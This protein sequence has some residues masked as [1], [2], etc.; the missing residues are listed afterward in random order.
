MSF[1]SEVLADNPTVFYKMNEP[2]GTVALDSSGNGFYGNYNALGV[3]YGQPSVVRGLV[4][5]S[6]I[7]DG[8]NG[9]LYCPSGVVASLFSGGLTVEAWVNPS[10]LPNNPNSNRIASS[11]N[12]SLDN[13]GFDFRADN[14]KLYVNFGNGSS[15]IMASATFPMMLNMWYHTVCTWDGTNAL[16]YV[17]GVLA[18]SA[19]STLGAITSDAVAF[20]FGYDFAIPGGQWVGSMTDAVL[21]NYALPASR[22]FAHYMAGV[23]PP[24]VDPFFYG[25]QI[26]HDGWNYHMIEKSTP[27]AAYQQS[28][29]PIARG[30]G[31]K[32]TG[33]R[34]NE[35]TINARIQV[36][37]QI[38][39]RVDLEHL[40]DNLYQGLS[41]RQ[42]P[43]NIHTTDE[44]FWIADATAAAAQLGPGNVVSAEVPVTFVS[45]QPY[46]YAP[47]TQLYQMPSAAMSFVSGTYLWITAVQAISVSGNAPSCP[48]ITITNTGAVTITAIGVYNITD[49][50]VANIF[51]SFAPGQTLTLQCDPRGLPYPYAC[52][53]GVA[54]TP[55]PFSGVM[56]VMEPGTTQYF[57]TAVTATNNQPS[58]S[59]NW[60]WTPRWLN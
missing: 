11:G 21:Y 57:I 46:A 26:I 43:L 34:Q 23:G 50:T 52:F 45:E 31:V 12:T 54:G 6:A 32:K 49:T 27:M 51:L 44:R 17:N 38:G 13:N 60:T 35:V 20:A 41:Y 15:T 7:F 10:A 42:Q 3:T 4:N 56:P 25:N 39:T 8:S 30:I 47:S 55:I 33:E 16:I 5:A 19:S 36:I 9:Y 40:L 59:A 14:T 58:I 18:G 1:D 53:V 37:S 28:T 22:I 2:T 48:L 24:N 29:Y